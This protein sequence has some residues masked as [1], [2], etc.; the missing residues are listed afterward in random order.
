[1]KRIGAQV[2]A[3]AVLV[4]CA[5]GPLLG[6]E[7]AT[8]IV[9]DRMDQM[10]EMG[11]VVKRINERIKAKRDLPEIERDAQALQQAA[12]RIPSLFPPGSRDA[13]SDVTNAVWERWEKFVHDARALER[14]AKNLGSVAGSGTAP[15]I[16][17]QFRAVNAACT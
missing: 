13:H 8:G 17:A 16:V 11:R 5:P 14:E 2:C 6:H 12:V 15:E 7:G 3:W 10:E 1:M 9:K 4:A